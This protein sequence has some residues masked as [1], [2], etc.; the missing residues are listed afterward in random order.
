MSSSLLQSE[1]ENSSNGQKVEKR[2]E[3]QAR[4]GRTQISDAEQK[5]GSPSSLRKPL[6]NSSILGQKYILEALTP[7]YYIQNIYVYIL[8]HMFIK[9]FGL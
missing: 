8:H 5:H 3:R 7:S 2:E 6:P 1:T 4:R 9:V